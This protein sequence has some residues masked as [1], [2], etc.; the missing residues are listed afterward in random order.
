ALNTMYIPHP[1]P[2]S[3]AAAWIASQAEA[4]DEYSFA[5]DDGQLTG[6]IG[7]RLTRMFERAEVG[8]WIGTPFWGRGYATEALAAVLRFGFEELRLHRI[9]AGYFSRNAASARVMEKND[10]QYEGRLREHV[11]KW[12]EFVDVVY[13]GILR[14]EWMGSHL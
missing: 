4:P 3:A 5:I 7:L 14:E 13:Y 2:E 1:Y 8:Y 10:M 12:D 9:Y 11:K 6:S